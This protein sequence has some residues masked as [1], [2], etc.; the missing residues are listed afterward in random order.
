MT[1]MHNQPPGYMALWDVADTYLR[2]CK[3]SEYRKLR[4]EKKLD[5]RIDG[6]IRATEDY[7]ARLIAEGEPV[8]IAW[9]RAVRS[10]ILESEEG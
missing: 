9:H 7:A 10:Q 8:D 2:N 4:K 5:E 1:I 3:A 6:L